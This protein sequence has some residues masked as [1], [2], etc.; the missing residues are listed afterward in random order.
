MTKIWAKDY[1]VDDIAQALS[2]SEKGR[3]IVGLVGIEFMELGDDF[4]SA[5]MPVDERTHQVHGILH[6][7]A[8]CVLAETVG[9]VASLLVVDMDKQ[10]AM[11]SFINANHVRPVSEGYVTATARPVH[12]GRSKHVWDIQVTRDDGKLVAKS[13]LTCAVVDK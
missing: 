10:Y 5:R 8:T 9:S 7:G 3:N 1:S 4:L 12:L 6:G 13:E 2:F 11:G